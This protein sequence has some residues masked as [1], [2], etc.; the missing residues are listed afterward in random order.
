V[1]PGGNPEVV[2]LLRRVVD[3]GEA[4]E[5][6]VAGISPAAP[7]E[8]HHWM[9]ALHP[10]RDAAG[11]VAGVGATVTDITER[12]AAERGVAFLA[13]AGEV[14]GR[15]LDFDTTLRGVASL[16]VPEL[17]D[18]CVV[19][20]LENGG[21]VRRVALAHADPELERLGWELSERYPPDRGAPG[22][23]TTM[24]HTRAPHLVTDIDDVALRA[25]A[26]DD[27]HY[28]AL[29]GLGLAAMLS[30][31]LTVRGRVIGALTLLFGHARRRPGAAELELAGELA[32]RAAT[33]IDNARLHRDRSHI[34]RTLQR[35]LLPP[36]LPRIDGFEVAARYRAAGEGIQLGGDFYDVFPRT[37]SSWIVALGDVCGKGAEAAA[38]TALARYTL[39]AAAIADGAPRALMTSLNE[40]ILREEDGRGPAV[41]Y[42]TAVVGCLD[43]DPVHPVLTVGVAGH[44]PPIVVRPDGTGEVLDLGGR[45]LGLLPG[46]DVGSR[47]VELRPGDTLLLYTDGVLDAGA[48]RAPLAV[49]ELCD[50]ACAAAR[51][52]AAELAEAVERAAL[53]RAVGPPRDDIAIVVLRRSRT[54]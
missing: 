45:A 11:A 8:R 2:A 52:P 5:A 40:A 21:A 48:P 6:E 12:V 19:D 1:L 7:G 30:A 49:E 23:M 34:A 47:K 20:L 43:V 50:A 18:W 33:A 4:V 16:A 9:V 54:G 42:M 53:E 51:A 46:V 37:D 41:R 17:A 15:S 22:G 27:A 3:T 25:M 24:L 29:R 44:P 31:P 36:R 28:D 35:S 10:V 39:R 32:G 26:R 14:L 38:L 13:R